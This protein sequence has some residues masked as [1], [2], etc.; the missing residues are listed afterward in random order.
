VTSEWKRQR[1]R[2]RIDDLAQS[3][4]DI[5]VLRREAIEI[6][7]ATIGFDRWCSLLLDPD[8]LVISQGIGHND[9]SSELPHLNLH[10]AGLGD[11]NNHAML[12]R[13]RNH[14][15]VLSAATGG[16]LARAGRWR[17]VFARYG[18]GDELACV[19]TDERGSWGDYRFW[20]NS[21]DAAFSAEDAQLM[22]EVAP[23]LARGLR[24]RAVTPIE[25]PTVAPAEMGV[26][27]LDH[28]LR[29]CGSTNAARAWLHALNPADTPFPDA[30]PGL[31]WNVVGRLTAIER[32][33]DPERPARV[34]ARCTHGG[35]AIVEAARLD[36]R[37]AGIAVSIRAARVDDVLGLLSRASGL[38][39]RE[40][41]LVALL[42]EGLGTRELAE[43]LVISR[44][45]VQ[46]HLKSVFEKVGVRSRRELISSVFAQAS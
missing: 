26:L 45:T 9:W 21:D 12:A 35:W 27:L 22:R 7:Q 44:H 6:L 29:L 2:E 18:V 13:S 33:E 15:G 46:D 24:R 37:G 41:E 39:P 17:N 42:V 8:T 36:D 30:I 32:G 5:D 14:V 25:G 3:S 11:V 1:C 4:A 43:R 20:R 19:A 10:E 38:T 16:D 31:V 23:A 28:E 40:C 34:R